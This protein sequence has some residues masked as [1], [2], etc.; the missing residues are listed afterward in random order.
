VIQS[1]KENKVH[2]VN[3]PQDIKLIVIKIMIKTQQCTEL[4]YQVK[5]NNIESREESHL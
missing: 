4:K 3:K 1:P 5:Q 2:I